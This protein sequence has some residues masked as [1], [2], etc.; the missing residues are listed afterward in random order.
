MNFKILSPSGV[1]VNAESTV[2][3]RIGEEA[4]MKLFLLI[5]LIYW[6]FCQ[7]V[8]FVGW[9]CGEFSTA[10]SCMMYEFSLKKILQSIYGFWMC[11]FL[12]PI[13]AEQTK[14]FIGF[15]AFSD[16]KMGWWLEVFPFSAFS[17]IYI[18]V[19][20]FILPCLYV[21]KCE[22]LNRKGDT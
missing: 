1:I 12:Y 22:Y 4:S 16:K 17:H 9:I 14:I 8:W 20:S 2:S 19:V 13:N 18:Y 3:L 5:C 6:N 10:L 11:D 21:T 7:C 15:N